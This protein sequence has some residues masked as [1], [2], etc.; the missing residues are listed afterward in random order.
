MRITK[1][2]RSHECLMQ[3]TDISDV[4]SIR[5]LYPIN[6]T[7]M[8]N[9]ESYALT[10]HFKVSIV[11]KGYSWKKMTI[12]WRKVKTL[13]DRNY[14]LLFSSQQGA[15]QMRNCTSSWHPRDCLRC[16]AVPLDFEVDRFLLKFQGLQFGV[17]PW[18]KVWEQSTRLGR[19]DQEPKETRHSPGTHPEKRGFTC[20]SKLL[21]ARLDSRFR[22]SPRSRN[23]MSNL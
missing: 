10:K 6:V 11:R 21:I 1:P 14:W 23:T 19:Q 9:L 22:H 2:R 12:M 4:F 8:Q 5:C 3:S 7:N 13:V 15:D 17:A 20:C 16:S 18:P